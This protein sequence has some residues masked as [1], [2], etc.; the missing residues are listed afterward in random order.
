[1]VP[2]ESSQTYKADATTPTTDRATRWREAEA[3]RQAI[4]TAFAKQANHVDLVFEMTWLD[5]TTTP[6]WEW[7][8]AFITFDGDY[9]VDHVRK[10]ITHKDAEAARHVFLQFRHLDNVAPGDPLHLQEIL[11]RWEPALTAP[12]LKRPASDIIEDVVPESVSEDDDTLPHGASKKQKVLFAESATQDVQ[13]IPKEVKLPSEVT[14][15]ISE[16]LVRV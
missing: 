7:H 13:P 15:M 16:F 1:V 5:G 9:H 12:Q 3:R 10:M 8:G 14:E 11:W 6:D 2:L 4:R